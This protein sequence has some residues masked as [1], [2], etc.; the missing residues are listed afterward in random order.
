VKCGKQAEIT[1]F[2]GL[3]EI[4]PDEF[5][6]FIGPNMRLEPVILQYDKH[7]RISPVYLMRRQ[8]GQSRAYI[9]DETIFELMAVAA[10][11]C[12]LSVAEQNFV[13][14]IGNSFLCGKA[15]VDIRR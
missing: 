13:I 3:G 11:Q 12:D 15:A 2:K 7:A 14:Q 1:R 5:R 4:S 9:M 8:I 10:F 6:A